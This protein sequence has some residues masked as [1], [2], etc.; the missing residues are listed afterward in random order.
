MRKQSVVAVVVVVVECAD[1]DLERVR[2]RLRSRLLSLA[3][4]LLRCVSC[5]AH[6]SGIRPRS[7]SSQA[8]CR[9]LPT[10]CCYS[11]LYVLLLATT[12][13]LL[14]T[15]PTTNHYDSLRLTKALPFTT[16][17]T[18][19][20]SLLLA[21]TRYY[22]PLLTTTRD[23]PL[24]LLTTT[25]LQAGCRPRAAPRSETSTP[26]RRAVALTP[27]TPQRDGTRW[28]RYIYRPHIYTL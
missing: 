28:H 22:S 2:S 8:G 18:R 25:S 4:S 3:C 19:S 26:R 1:L 11:L 10:P 12:H 15:P 27:P 5:S 7:A 24:L 6:C 20:S 21:T 9:P 13:S 14:R 17:N 23:Y 16:T